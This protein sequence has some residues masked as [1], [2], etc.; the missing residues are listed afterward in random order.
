MSKGGIIAYEGIRPTID[1]TAFVAPGAHIIGKVEVGAHA[2][3]WYNCV[4]RGDQEPIHIGARSNVQDG[5]VIHTSL[6]IADTWIGEDVLIGHM[7]IIHGARL[8]NRAFVG[9]G[10]VV[11]DGAVI[12]TGAMLAAGATLPPGKRIPSGQIW[13]GNPAKFM[14]D[15]R[16]EEPAMHVEMVEQYVEL[17]I[18]H[19]AALK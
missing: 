15:L 3:V 10:A 19:A 4:V 16:P 7:C 14:R 17:A 8:E 12:E 5:S 2:S 18:K 1:P 13:S 11:L 9:M 6:G